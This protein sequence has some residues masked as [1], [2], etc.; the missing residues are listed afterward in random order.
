MSTA[1]QPRVIDTSIDNPM[2]AGLRT[3]S[4]APV[5]IPNSKLKANQQFF[6]DLEFVYQTLA[7][8]TGVKDLI[9]FEDKGCETFVFKFEPTKTKMFTPSVC[10]VLDKETGKHITVIRWGRQVFPLTKSLNK[11]SYVVF[12]F[13]NAYRF[14]DTVKV[15]AY[16][17]DKSL[18][19]TFKNDDGEYIRMWFRIQLKWGKDEKTGKSILP[20]VSSDIL[21]L[22]MYPEGDDENDSI[23]EKFTNYLDVYDPN[24]SG[25]AG[26]LAELPTDQILALVHA[27]PKKTV[28][29][30]TYVV[31]IKDE[32][33]TTYNV[34]A[35]S[36]LKGRLNAG[37]IFS[38]ELP[39]YATLSLYRTREG[40]TAAALNYQ[41]EL[42]FKSGSVAINL[43]D[44][45]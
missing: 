22:A 33:G 25:K 43:D 35:N 19:I 30:P 3:N 20:Q 9:G 5:Y 11:D 4:S 40:K 26:K 8:A 7:E 32:Q 29:G 44:L 39:L 31:T 28:N 2:F 6:D 34:W 12:R 13:G 15:G 42:Q 10:S 14:S 17:N 27:E 38:P 37:L 18:G 16:S 1:E 36:D 24:R 45:V 41:G 21:E 23:P